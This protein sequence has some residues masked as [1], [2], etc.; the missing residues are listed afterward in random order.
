M[1][2]CRET[3]TDFAGERQLQAAGQNDHDDYGR[4]SMILDIL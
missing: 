3:Y 2:Y 4:E 1:T